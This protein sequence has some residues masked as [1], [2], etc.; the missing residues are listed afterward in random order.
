MSHFRK[1]PIQYFS[2]GKFIINNQEHS[3]N[4]KIIGCGKD[5]RM[6]GSKV[7]AWEEREG[8]LLKKSMITGIYNQGVDIL[9]VGVGVERALK[10]PR[11]V[12]KAI[13]NRGI[14][15]VIVKSTPKACKVYNKLYCRGKKVALLAHGTC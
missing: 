9:V 1:G 15:R 7:T 3:E 6:V 12:I 8:H 10:C 4:E 13:H 14:K 2:W 5:I 11:K